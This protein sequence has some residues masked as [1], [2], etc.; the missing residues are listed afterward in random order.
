VSTWIKLHDNLFENPKILAAGDDAALLYIQGLLYCSRNLTDG[1]IPTPALR[2]LTARRDARTL[3]RV[4][5]REGLWVETGTGWEVHEYLLHQR[6]KVTILREREG[7]RNRVAAFRERKRNG[8]SNGP[9]TA[10]ETETE[11]DNP[12]P[13]PPPLSL[14]TD[15][16]FLADPARVMSRATISP[17]QL[18]YLRAARGDVFTPKSP[19]LPDTTQADAHLPRHT[20]GTPQAQPEGRGE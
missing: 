17:R 4:L 19:R 13:T 16:G 10:P 15:E 5:V 9:V 2:M 7:T 20:S 8:A 11:T 12:T 18:E 1:R 14:V 3:A 6:S